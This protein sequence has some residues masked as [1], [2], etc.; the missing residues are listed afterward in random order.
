M[1]KKAICKNCGAV[2]EINAQDLAEDDGTDWLACDLP[3]GFEWSLPAGKISPVYGDPIYVSS[4]GQHM[5]REEYILEFDIDPE[6]AYQKMRKGIR[7]QSSSKTANQSGREPARV[8]A[9]ALRSQFL[10]DDDDWTA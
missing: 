1:M 5:S 3:L 8:S 4:Q 2:N 10:L 7:G 9:K 6:I